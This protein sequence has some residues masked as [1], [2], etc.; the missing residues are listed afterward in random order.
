[1]ATSTHPVGGQVQVRSAKPWGPR[2]NLELGDHGGIAWARGLA[3]MVDFT[4]VRGFPWRQADPRHAIRSQFVLSTRPGNG[5][6]PMS[7][8]AAFYQYCAGRYLPPPS[9][10]EPSSSATQGGVHAGFRWRRK[11]GHHQAGG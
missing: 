1:M 3:V 7:D 11:P 10:H 8:R 6:A 2:L 4:D 9:D 5:S